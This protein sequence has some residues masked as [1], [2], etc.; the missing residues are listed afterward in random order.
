MSE[1]GI[2]RAVYLAERIGFKVRDRNLA[3][4]NETLSHFYITAFSLSFKV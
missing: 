2:F 3:H 1:R 4:L